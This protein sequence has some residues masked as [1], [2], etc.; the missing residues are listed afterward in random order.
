[1]RTYKPTGRNPGAPKGNTNALKH[2]LYTSYISL[3]E[4]EALEPM[5][6]DKSDDELS[7]ARV[8][9]KRCLQKQEEAS[10]DKWLDYERLIVAY[11]HLIVS[12]THKN[13]LLGRDHRPG[14]ITVMEMVQQVNEEQDVS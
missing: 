9:L 14:Y 6:L 2:G 13:A 1:M 3:S 5:L 11:T 4:Q 7:L 8:R 10:P 12:L